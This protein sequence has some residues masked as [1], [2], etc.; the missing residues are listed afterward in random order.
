M[1]DF[2]HNLRSGKLKQ[3][4]RSNRPYN[5]QQYKGGQRRPMMDRRKKEFDNKE[6]IER[7]AAMKEVLET[8]AETQKRIA[9]AHETRNMVEERKANAMEVLARNIYQMLNPNADNIETLFTPPSASAPRKQ[10]AAEKKSVVSHKEKITD[11]GVGTEKADEHLDSIPQAQD[12]VSSAGGDATADKQSNKLT[13]ADQ[14]TLYPVISQMREN[15]TSWER[16][17]R[18]IAD[19]GYPTLSGKSHWRGVMVKNLF[20]KMSA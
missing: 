6:S 8:L 7:L 5:D 19:Q 15:G 13:P 2:L 10:R 18:H 9:E 3:Q 20:E 16:I 17:A 14:E 1:D 12:D 11:S 4:D